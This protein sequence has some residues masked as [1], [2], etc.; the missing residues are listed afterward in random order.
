[1]D[2][3]ATD[4]ITSDLEKLS[5][6]DKYHGG[7]YV[8][9]ANGSGMEISHVGHGFVQSPSHRIH[10]RNILHVPG[11]SKSLVSVNRLSRD[12]NAFVEFHPDCFFTK[13]LATKKT[14]LIGKAEGGLYPIK[15]FSSR[16]SSSSNK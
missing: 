4:H 13:E 3:G 11:A 15:S 5:L 8:H 7:E 14:L 1:M 2:S 12:K 10:L 9:A 6:C 16:S